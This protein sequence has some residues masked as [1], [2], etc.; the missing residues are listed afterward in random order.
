MSSIG[1]AYS[2]AQLALK[3]SLRVLLPR[4]LSYRLANWYRARRVASF[5]RREIRRSYYGHTLRLVIADTTA[6]GWYDFEWGKNL[7]PELTYLRQGR[8]RPGARVFDIG[9][10]QG[11]VAHILTRLVGIEGAVIAVEADPWNAARTKENVD[12]NRTTGLTVLHAAVSDGK[13]KD[14]HSRS[15][16]S[17]RAF[18]WSLKRVPQITIDELSQRHGF[19][20]VVYMDVDGF[21]L[22]A[23]RGATKTLQQPA[24]WY[25]EVHVGEGLENEGATWQEI[26]EFFDPVRFRLLIGTEESP[27]FTA[28][29]PYSHLL[30]HRFFLV[31]LHK[32]VHLSKEDKLSP[33]VLD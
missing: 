21:E 33:G 32:E 9:A 10:H 1:A 14:H 17:D 3:S 30:E 27:E 22:L 16:F 29:D 4:T 5:P 31:A 15:Y 8:L 18:D 20:D 7:L 19:P 2:T 28:F 25:V 13:F 26:L 6:E 12:L 11:V 24:D 23:L